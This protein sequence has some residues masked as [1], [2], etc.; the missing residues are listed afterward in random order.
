MK[1]Q[2]EFDL[3]S[4]N[5]YQLIQIKKSLIPNYYLLTFPKNQGQPTSEEVTEMLQLGINH[6]QSIAY[7][8]L[9]DKEAFSILY[10]GYS[11]RREKGWHVH[12]VLLGNRWKKA[13]LY[14]VL[15]AKN[16]LQA[17]RLRK[18]DAPRLNAK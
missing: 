13:W 17:L 3:S 8:L 7:D 16:L 15:S 6:A 9:N 14:I 11:A 1:T 12:I 5:K 4:G 10:S 2:K 18:D